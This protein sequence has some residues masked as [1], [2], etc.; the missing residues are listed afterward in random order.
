MV[1]KT[2]HLKTNMFKQHL[3]QMSL[4]EDHENFGEIK[5]KKKERM[6]KACKANTAT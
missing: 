1:L 5:L 6:V 3:R 2:L 4:Y